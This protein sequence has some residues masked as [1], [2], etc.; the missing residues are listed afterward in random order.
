[1]FLVLVNLK[2]TSCLTLMITGNVTFS[3]VSLI[4]MERYRIEVSYSNESDVRLK[5]VSKEDTFSSG[6]TADNLKYS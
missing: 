1:M 4:H 3:Q 5:N 6:L 2:E